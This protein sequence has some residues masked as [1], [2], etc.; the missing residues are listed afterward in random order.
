[1][2]LRHLQLAQ[3]VGSNTE[4]RENRGGGE[5]RWKLGIGCEEG[6][7]RHLSME[8]KVRGGGVRMTSALPVEARAL[9]DFGRQL[10][11]DAIIS[12]RFRGDRAAPLHRKGG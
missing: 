8:G 9:A 3:I 7:T 1:V 12:Q 11:S 4:T 10:A 5:E 2:R 6:G